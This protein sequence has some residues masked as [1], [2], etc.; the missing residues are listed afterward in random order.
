MTQ[1]SR[2]Y[3][4]PNYNDYATSHDRSIMYCRIVAASVSSIFTYAKLKPLSMNGSNKHNAFGSSSW[5]F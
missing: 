5:S 2:V 4:R 1:T 3:L